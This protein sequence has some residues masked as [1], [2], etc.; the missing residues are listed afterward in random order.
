MVISY[1]N[2]SCYSDK[3]YNIYVVKTNRRFL[4]VIINRLIRKKYID[5]QRFLL[6]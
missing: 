3:L 5:I 4:L 6:L 1:K 2:M